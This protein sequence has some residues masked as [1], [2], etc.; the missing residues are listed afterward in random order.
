MQYCS[1]MCVNAGVRAMV[2]DVDTAQ[3]RLSLGLKASYFDGAADA[4]EE[5][6][7]KAEV[8]LHVHACLLS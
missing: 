5:G 3:R 8:Q 4:E 6:D 7:G 2:L 1:T